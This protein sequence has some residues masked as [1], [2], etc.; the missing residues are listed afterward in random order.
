MPALPG[1]LA[2]T[3]I[4][5]GASI[6]A[7]DHRNNYTAIQTAVNALIALLANGTLDGDPLVWDATNTKWVAASSLAAGRPRAPRVV[8]SAMSG[9]PPASPVDQDIWIA[10]AVDGNGT[11]W[12]F[13]YNAGSASASK[14]EFIGGPPLE[15]EVATDEST[16]SA[17]YVDLTTVQSLTQPRSGDYQLQWGGNLYVSAGAGSILTAPSFGGG[18]PSDANA[19]FSTLN[20]ATIDT[21]QAP[22][23]LR[24]NGLGASTVIK[25][26][27]RVT[28]GATMHAR[29]RWMSLTPVRIS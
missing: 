20:A 25:I 28:G 12:A 14:W 10:T 16:A 22:K 7:A 21:Q 8:T 2:L 23:T 11:R 3:N 9:G 26:Q 18:A 17:A 19:T 1:S 13:Q 15:A 4:P 29:G 27:Y 6:I 5:D 24:T